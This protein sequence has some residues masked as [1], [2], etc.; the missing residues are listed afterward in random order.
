M[1]NLKQRIESYNKKFDEYEN[2]P[3]K[4]EQ[5]FEVIEGKIPVLLSAPHSVDN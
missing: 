3:L 2:K 1:E 4:E 5:T